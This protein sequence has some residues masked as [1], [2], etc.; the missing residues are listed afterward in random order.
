[1]KTIVT[2]IALAAAL[3]QPASAVTFASLT[4]IYVGSGVYD[5]GTADNTGEANSIHCSQCER[6]LCSGARWFSA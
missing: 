6:R 2:G 5:G 1:M 4:M 3:A